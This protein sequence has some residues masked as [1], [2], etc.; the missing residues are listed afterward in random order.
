MILVLRTDKPEAEIGLYIGKKQI[1]Y[2]VWTAHRQ[3][4]EKLHQE[5]YSM[6]KRREQ[7][8]HDITGIV[9]YKGPGSFT[10]LRI[11]ITVADTLASSLSVPIIGEEGE[12]WLAT[13]LARL[14]IGEDDTLVIPEYG[15]DVHISVPRK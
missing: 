8:W 4:A 3:L 13:G 10:G 14:S 12:T 15:Q 9:A 6:L 1:D 7:N 2:H 5:I 11:G